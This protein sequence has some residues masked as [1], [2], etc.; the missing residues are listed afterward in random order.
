MCLKTATAD[1][2]CCDQL[3][4]C[5]ANTDC[6]CIIDCLEVM[7]M[8]VSALAACQTQCDTGPTLPPGGVDLSACQAVSCPACAT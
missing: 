2:G 8:G 3:T 5:R 7:D 4:T 1:G 6:N